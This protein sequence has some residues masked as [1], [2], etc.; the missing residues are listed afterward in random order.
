MD[1]TWGIYLVFLHA[2]KL[3]G[4]DDLNV[5]AK[6]RDIS[7]MCKIICGPIFSSACMC[8]LQQTEVPQMKRRQP[9][10]VPAV[11]FGRKLI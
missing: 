3:G 2:E 6:N 8:I 5:Y 11:L 10:K 1:K 9:V 7:L 4:Q